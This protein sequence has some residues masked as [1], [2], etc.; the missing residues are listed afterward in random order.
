[1]KEACADAP[2]HFMK[3]DLTVWYF[4]LAYDTMEGFMPLAQEQLALSRLPAQDAE[5]MAKVAHHGYRPLPPFISCVDV[6]LQEVQQLL[7]LSL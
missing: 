4:S 5:E 2:Y 1:M 6:L 7:L 3:G